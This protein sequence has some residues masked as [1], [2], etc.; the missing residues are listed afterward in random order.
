MAG[1][2]LAETVDSSD[3]SKTAVTLEEV[4]NSPKFFNYHEYVITKYRSLTDDS[5]K[6]HLPEDAICITHFPNI[7]VPESSP[8]FTET[9]IIRIP[10]RFDT[11]V[12][13][14]FFSTDLPGSEPAAMTSDDSGCFIGKG[15]YEGQIYGGSSV[16]PLSNYFTQEQWFKIV[17]TINSLLSSA[18]NPLTFRN[19]AS[20]T[21]D[22][23][24]LNLWSLIESKLLTDPLQKLE[25]YVTTLNKTELFKTQNISIISPR[26][27]SYLSVCTIPRCTTTFQPPQD[28][29]TNRYIS[30]IQLDVQIPKPLS[31]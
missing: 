3:L 31:P 18:Y 11:C 19:F 30:L 6:E 7:Y 27:S 26:K 28:S 9:R 15:D 29:I 24:T 16:S 22:L 1:S 8:L 21:L 23:I 2:V 12:D 17:S 25:D 13:R 20:I 4:P 5:I 10:R 14:P